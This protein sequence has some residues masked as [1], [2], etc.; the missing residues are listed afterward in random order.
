MSW[1]KQKQHLDPFTSVPRSALTPGFAVADTG[2][3]GHALLATLILVATLAAFVALAWPREQHTVCGPEAT[4][5][6]AV[7]WLIDATDPLSDAQLGWVTG[8]IRRSAE[9]LPTG[10]H[11]AILQLDPK[12][13]DGVLGTPLETCKP[14]DGSH[15]NA[16]TENARLLADQ[17]Q[18]TFLGPL[19]GAMPRLREPLTAETSALL[20]ALHAIALRLAVADPGS[21]RE[22][23]I[24]SYM[25]QHSSLL[26][27][28]RGGY[29]FNALAE[30]GSVYLT[31]LDGLRGASVTI[32]Q[33]RDHYPQRLTAEHRRF[34]DEY[35]TAVGVET[36]T[37]KTL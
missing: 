21:R 25:L 12:G 18:Q 13:T 23:I 32:Y 28:F 17:F 16:W 37:V 1:L 8:E 20:E 24:V 3:R 9:H 4:P 2:G 7:V 27:H 35:F 26:S 34:W 29:S 11:L 22:L 33:I 36:L 19:E 15:A 31:R 10:S 5:A 30:G 6:A 14:N